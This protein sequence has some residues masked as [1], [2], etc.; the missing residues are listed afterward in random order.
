MTGKESLDGATDERS[1]RK[2]RLMHNLA[3][4]LLRQQFQTLQSAIK[5]QP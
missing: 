4:E 2:T 3:I 1:G 5:L